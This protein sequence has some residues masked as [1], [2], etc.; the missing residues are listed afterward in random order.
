VV[1]RRKKKKREKRREVG[2]A[3]KMGPLRKYG[4]SYL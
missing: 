3:K 1:Y 2:W 4:L